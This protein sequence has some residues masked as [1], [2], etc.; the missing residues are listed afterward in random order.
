MGRKNL[1]FLPLLLMALLCQ[2]AAATA[3]VSGEAALREFRKPARTV[4]SENGVDPQ[5]IKCLV[6]DP[7]GFL[8][9]ASE[10]GL[11]V[12]NF[13]DSL[14][15]VRLPGQENNPGVRAL[16]FEPLDDADARRNDAGGIW[17]LT[18]GGILALDRSGNCR[19]ITMEGLPELEAVD[20]AIDRGRYKYLL[21]ADGS[22]YSMGF[23]KKWARS[24][25]SW[26][27]VIAPLSREDPF[28]FKLLGR[29]FYAPYA[30]EN[31]DRLRRG[32]WKD[33]SSPADLSCRFIRTDWRKKD[34][35][36]S[37]GTIR[38]FLPNEHYAPCA[39]SCTI[40][41]TD[42]GWN[43]LNP[44]YVISGDPEG[45][46]WIEAAGDFS[47]IQLL[48]LGVYRGLGGLFLAFE[49]NKSYP[50][51]EKYPPE[52]EKYLG[53]REEP[54]SL[55]SGLSSILNGLVR[56]SS[57]EDMLKTASDI[58][59]SPLFQMMAYDYSWERLQENP[60]SAVMDAYSFDLPGALKNNIG[61][62]YTKSQLFA[63]LAR[64][65]GIPARVVFDGRAWNEIW[66]NRLG[67]IPVEVTRPLYDYSGSS[68][69]R[70]ELPM[71][72]TASDQMVTGITGWGD[73]NSSLAWYPN[74]EA[75]YSRPGNHR[76]LLSPGKLS[77]ARLMAIRPSDTDNLPRESLLPLGNGVYGFF[78]KAGHLVYL[79]LRRDNGEDIQIRPWRYLNYNVTNRYEIK[80]TLSWEF[81]A[82][83]AGDFLIIE[84]ISLKTK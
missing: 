45:N 17:F 34:D 35:D 44:D 60:Q 10:S 58:A 75:F 48:T 13:N 78:R 53:I 41:W 62:P 37:R 33:K 52:V 57:K 46:Q 18:S 83:R 28:A 63:A 50:F 36:N 71:A 4:L 12:V 2:G 16:A 3:Q 59:F 73:R 47:G 39:W 84:N 74:V 15:R 5:S 24:E 1:A 23:E 49:K 43:P 19:Q 67:W 68:S 40:L 38:F 69:H 31:A 8:W 70:L 51:P 22:V 30:W 82:R 9:A 77:G 54:A 42:R 66:I 6:V 21:M 55:N 32:I 80:D 25:S 27:A 79:V 76:E 26:D 20:L 61:D 81:I 7:G 14:I 11:F 29:R 56:D 72:G 65:A 64:L